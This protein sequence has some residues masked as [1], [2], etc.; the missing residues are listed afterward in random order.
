MGGRT[1]ETERSVKPEL[2][3]VQFHRLPR[4]IGYSDNSEQKELTQKAKPS[5]SSGRSLLRSWM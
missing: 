1:G 3:V 5:R 4:E 2:C